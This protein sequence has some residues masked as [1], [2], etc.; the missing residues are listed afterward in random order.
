MPLTSNKF[1]KI[2]S[3]KSHT[4]LKSLRQIFKYILHSS[5]DFYLIQYR[6]YSQ[7]FT[8]WLW[9]PQ[10][11][12]GEAILYFGN[13]KEYIS[14]LSLFIFRFE[15]NMTQE[16]NTYFCLAFVSFTNSVLRRPQLSYEH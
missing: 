14:L 5:S 4:F 1:V 6:I 12:R 13:I 8:R 11:K 3:V 10:K 2:G 7:Q 9:V 16:I 15:W